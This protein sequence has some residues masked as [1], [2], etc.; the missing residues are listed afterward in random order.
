S[1]P[2]FFLCL[3]F[4]SLFSLYLLRL[5]FFS[6][7]SSSVQIDWTSTMSAE[8]ENLN[9]NR[10]RRIIVD[11]DFDADAVIFN[12]ITGILRA[13][14]QMKEKAALDGQKNEATITSLTSEMKERFDALKSKLEKEM[15]S[16]AKG[17]LRSSKEKV[18][19]MLSE[20]E[21]ATA[22][23]I[24]QLEESLKKNKQD[25][26]LSILKKSL[27]SFLGNALDEGFPLDDNDE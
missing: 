15:E 21:K 18:K 20:H 24:A 12:H 3:L 6:L 13:L 19:Y 17:M 23:K 22:E 4:D 14:Q 8:P 2:L 9:D 5:S 27:D 25:D 1:F 16:F 7:S 11:E 26:K 10:R